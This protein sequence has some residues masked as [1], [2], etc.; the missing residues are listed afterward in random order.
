MN[1][2]ERKAII[3]RHGKEIIRSKIV[4]SS[5]GIWLADIKTDGRKVTIVS[6]D[7]LFNTEEEIFSFVDHFFNSFLNTNNNRLNHPFPLP[8]SYKLGK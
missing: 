5:N 8:K 1:T 3:Y 2:Y 4:I 7:H 6:S